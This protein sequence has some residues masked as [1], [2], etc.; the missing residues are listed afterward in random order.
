MGGCTSNSSSD[1]GAF[2]LA[3]N[4]SSVIPL[5]SLVAYV[6]GSS[7]NRSGATSGNYLDSPAS[8]SALTYAVQWRSINGGTF[9]INDY[10]YAGGIG[11]SNITLMEIAA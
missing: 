6:S 7:A 1:G 2:Q 10:G 3:R 9:R 8:T 11:Y 4:G 5:D